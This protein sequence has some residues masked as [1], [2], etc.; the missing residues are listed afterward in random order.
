MDALAEITGP[1]AEKEASDS[2]GWN[3]NMTFAIDLDR[4][5]FVDP[6]FA[7]AR[8]A[9]LC[10]RRRQEAHDDCVE[11]KLCKAER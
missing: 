7:A 4:D 8:G 6:V 11:H 1:Y 3:G 2:N 5:M 10:A 9:A